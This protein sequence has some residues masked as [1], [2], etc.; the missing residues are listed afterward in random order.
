VSGDGLISVEEALTRLLSGAV[1]LR[2]EDI[3]LSRANGR[4]LARDLAAHRDQPPFPASA[5]DGYAV[6]AEDIAAPPAHLT[7][8]GE[9]PAGH[10]FNG[11]V[12]PGEAVRI[13][14]GAPV[15]EGADTILI[16]ENATREGERVT[17]LEAAAPGRFIRAAGL[18]FA[19]G[20]VL[21]AQGRRLGFRELALAA[22][23][24]HGSVS[25]HRKPKV[26][27]LATGD[28]LV[29]PGG[30]PAADQIIAS[31]DTGLA[32]FV[33]DCGGEAIMLGIA[34]DT[35]E[36]LAE[37]IRAA[38]AAGADILV[39]LGG[40]SVGDHDL[41]QDALGNAGMDLSFWRIA[42]R[43]GKPLMAGRIDN[44]RV[45]GL[46]GNPVSSLVCALLFLKPLIL[47]LSGHPDAARPRR[48][49][50]PL[51][52]PVPAND[53]REDYLRASLVFG[54]DGVERVQPFERQDS[55]MLATFARADALVVRPPH[56]KAL[57]PGA[58]V[59]VLR[60][61]RG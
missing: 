60:L 49:M 15:P 39:T 22:A 30:D 14:T 45:L 13:F 57:E 33:E 48:E 2:S 53:R 28:E 44:M 40:A 29:A 51:A 23:M 17:V 43:P 47:A 32:A 37:R 35:H 10:A 27:V 9:A 56:A 54:D 5:M 36:A 21:L 7:V 41:V 20:E 24:N 3:A 11:R 58:P 34:R 16:Q 59:P 12:G 42:M 52:S 55:S 4:V 26:A 25:V 31:N 61:H 50:L 6:R 38:Q 18:D 1:P 46:P 19:Q 8:I